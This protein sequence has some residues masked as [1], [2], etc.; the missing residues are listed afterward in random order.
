M[1]GEGLP[2]Q[3]VGMDGNYLYGKVSVL[4]KIKLTG[5]V[6]PMLLPS[7]PYHKQPS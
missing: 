2:E 3:S 6:E 7:S 1:T 5:D 4:W